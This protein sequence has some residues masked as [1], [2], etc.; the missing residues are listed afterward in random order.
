[1]NKLAKSV[2]IMSVAAI[3]AGGSVFAKSAVTVKYA[4]TGT[5]KVVLRSLDD[6]S[7]TKAA[8]SKLAAQQA[9]KKKIAKRKKNKKFD[10]ETPEERAERLRRLK[11]MQ[12][13]LAK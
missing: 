6:K 9:K 3:L 5:S 4:S 11:E 13:P 10:D 8:P 12:D 2:T 7:T 1:M